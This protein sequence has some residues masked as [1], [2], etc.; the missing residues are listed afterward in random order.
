MNVKLLLI[1]I[2]LIVL[3]A[4]APVMPYARGWGWGP[5]GGVG[6]LLVVLLVLFLL[7]II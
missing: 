6:A 7:G 2:L 4:G 3:F 5:S 1:I